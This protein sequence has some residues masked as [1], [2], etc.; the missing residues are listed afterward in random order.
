[1]SKIV[2]LP[3]HV[4]STLDRIFNLKNLEVWDK[5]PDAI[6]LDNL[7]GRRFNHRDHI[8][9]HGGFNEA[10]IEKEQRHISSFKLN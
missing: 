8:K 6:I 10:L 5:N 3:V 2:L 4:T 9:E 1:M 7:S